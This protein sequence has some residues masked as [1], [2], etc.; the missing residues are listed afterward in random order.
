MKE[1]KHMSWSWKK[2]LLTL[3]TGMLALAPMASARP[4]YRSGYGFGYGYGGGFYPYYWGGPAYYGAFPLTNTGEVKIVT[5][6]KDALIYVDGGYAGLSG[7]LKK[8]PLRP[9]NHDIQLRDPSGKTF[10]QGRVQVIIGK[11]TEIHAGPTS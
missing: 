1:D 3:G 10:Y 7:K 5:Q 9:G 8:F 4:L 2:S 6:A 11:T